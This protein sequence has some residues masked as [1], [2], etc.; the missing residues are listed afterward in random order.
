MSQTNEKLALLI[1]EEKAAEKKATA[2]GDTNR[3]WQHAR[4]LRELQLTLWQRLEPGI[5]LMA[6]GFRHWVR[7]SGLEVDDLLQLAYLKLD[8]VL[9]RYQPA[10]GVP[11]HAWLEVVFRNFFTQLGRR[12]RREQQWSDLDTI[13]GRSGS[14]PNRQWSTSIIDEL[15]EALLPLDRRRRLKIDLFKRH[16]EGFTMV[17][18]AGSQGVSVTTVFRWIEAVRTAL[19]QVLC[20]D[21]PPTTCAHRLPQQDAA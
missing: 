21:S 11:L 4:R 1:R 12:R 17:E 6:H 2:F 18:L 19:A 14:I 9:D 10:K 8:H 7:R 13:E 20:K 15:S 5:K 3:A 16:L